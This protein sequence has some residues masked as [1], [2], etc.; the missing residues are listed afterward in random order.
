M[1]AQASAHERAAASRPA[2]EG[3]PAEAAGVAG[4]RM[5]AAMGTLDILSI[6][7]G[8]R[9]GYYRLL[10]G[11]EPLTPPGLPAASRTAPLGYLRALAEDWLAALPGVQQRLRAAR[12]SAWPISAGPA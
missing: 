2:A 4:R 9:L 10:A 11:R 8:E 3:E 1:D 6:A 5:A 7:L 12:P